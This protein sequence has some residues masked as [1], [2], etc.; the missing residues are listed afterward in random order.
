MKLTFLLTCVLCLQLSANVHSQTRVTLRLRQATLGHVFL[1]IEKKTDYRFVFNDNLLQDEALVNVDVNNEPVTEFLTRL[2]ADTKLGY[3]AINGSLIVIVSKGEETK[4]VTIHGKVIN[5]QSQAVAGAT[6][7]EKGTSNGVN[8]NEQGEF[9]IL[10][11]NNQAVLVVSSVGYVTLEHPL[12]GNDNVTISLSEDFS[13]LNDV[14]VVGYG[15]ARRKDVMGAVTSVKV[16]GS[17]L[18]LMPN[19]NALEALRGNVSGLNLGPVNTAGGQPSTLIRG[20][21][22]ISGSN[23]PL[24][25][26][27]GVIYLG[28]ISDINPNDIAS[29]DI[30]KDAVSAATYGSRSANGIIAINT[31][32][33]KSGKPVIN[34]KTDQALQRWQKRPK[35]MKGQEWIEVV[36]ARNKYAPGSLNW[37]MPGELENYNAGNETDWLDLVTQ[38]GVIQD[39]SASVSGAAA[40]VNYYLSSSYNDNKGIVVGDKFNRL[41]ALGKVNT[42]ITSWFELGVDAGWSKR[43]YS[44][45]AASISAAQLMS[46]YGVVYRDSLGHLEKFPYTQSLA[47]PLWGIQDG[48]VDNVD[49]YTTFRLNT[50]AVVSVPWIKG[51]SY[52]LNLLNNQARRESGSFTYETYYVKEGSGIPGRYD[53]AS[54]QS[55]LANANGNLSDSTAKS[56][57]LDNILTYDR[58]IGQHHLTLTGVATRDHFRYEI[59]NST[60]SNFTANGNTAL[61]IYGLSKAA[62]QKVNLTNGER[63][64]IGYL[65]RLNYS[66]N[67]KYFLTASWRRDGASVFGEDKRWA[68]FAAIGGAWRAS[69]EP[70]LAGFTPLNDLKLKFS[71]GQNGNQG[72]SPYATLSQVANGAAGNA[73]YEFSNALGTVYYGLVQNTLGNSSLGWEKTAAT[74]FGFT[75]GWLGNRLFVDLD[76]YFSKT[77]DQ[78]F[79]RTIP[80]MTGFKDQLSS[81]GQVN[82]TGVELT[83]RTVNLQ[84]KNLSWNSELTFWKNN[85]KLKHLYQEDKNND[86]HED[87]DIANNFFIGKPLGAIYGYKQDGIVQ[88]KD[89]DYIAMTGAA[90]GAPKYVDLIPDGKID[91]DDRT[92][93]GYEKENFRLN[94]SNTVRYKK[95]DVY[96]MVSGIF[97]GNNT[98]LRSNTGAFMTSGTGRFND[99]SISKP[100]WTP[101]NPSNIYPS[102]YFSGD[103]RFLGLQSRSF[104]RIQDLSIAYSFDG[105]W[106]KQNH[107]NSLRLFASGRNLATFTKWVGGDPETGTTVQ[108][109][110]FPVPTSY[111]LGANLSF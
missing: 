43:D 79:L 95:F 22:S 68:N 27:D 14:V 32:K 31:K 54:V 78:I 76:I 67:D 110:T 10:V 46:P 29:F 26:L 8:A 6:V 23:D 83:V 111:S 84:R 87:D 36:N 90:P 109:N 20:Q 19:M 108:S 4:A 49:I 57:V 65:A 51:L 94:L 74:N 9:N 40:N 21:R 72:L 107:V 56:Y 48:T 63:S 13:K 52:R 69:A 45:N 37:L 100:Y 61:G 35:M 66:F 60:G 2:L 106:L 30:L 44:G 104:V 89:D 82:N 5:A 64:N 86:G 93:V 98:Y 85:N 17:A 1:E 77:T 25:L 103:S 47:N 75:S 55:L 11:T 99:N 102:A 12:N 33:G 7:Q 41:S 58:S 105:A 91:P 97:G 70:F 50:Y 15:T 18:S 80:I 16:D 62:V 73:R 88:A 96:L 101:D 34:V 38:T 42:K 28:A 59:N 24:I 53:P 81:L 39:Y 92:I 3:K 71:W